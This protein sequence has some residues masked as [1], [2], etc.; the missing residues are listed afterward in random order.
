[1]QQVINCYKKPGD[2]KHTRNKTGDAKHARNKP[3]DA[4]HDRDAPTWLSSYNCLSLLNLPNVMAEFGPIRSLWEGG[5]QGEG[6]L[7]E[8]KPQ[9]HQMNRRNF[10]LF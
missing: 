2:S 3:S 7:R 1:M 4:K 6:Y 10:I 8:A 5:N 9:I